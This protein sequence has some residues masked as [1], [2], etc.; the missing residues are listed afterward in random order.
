[1]TQESKNLPQVP[2]WL[3]IMSILVIAGF[4]ISVICA[5]LTITH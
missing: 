2:A 4:F 5:A 1:M 3:L